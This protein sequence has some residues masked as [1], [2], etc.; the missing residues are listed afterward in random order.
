MKDF[1]NEQ[2]ESDVQSTEVSSEPTVAAVEQTEASSEAAGAAEQTKPESNVPYSRFQEV[3]QQKNQHA[4]QLK[5]MQGQY[6][7]MQAR[8]DAFER[9]QQARPQTEAQKDALIERLKGIDPE[10]GE[11]IEQ[12][13]S[14]LSKID[15]LDQWRAQQEQQTQYQRAMSA[16][17]RL[18]AEHKVPKELQD[19]Y[20]NQLKSDPHVNLDNLN[21]AYKNLHQRM[22]GY[23]DSVKRT[24]R[25]SYVA[26]KKADA[27]APT[28]QPKGK[29]PSPAQ[30]QAK[31]SE[32][33]QRET[34]DEVL[35][36]IR[37]GRE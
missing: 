24:E 30:K 35:S 21:E 26:A 13:Y 14:K 36:L 11:R 28:S 33:S 34:V 5:A 22:S 18:H 16:V 25:E 19:I 37:A 8:I 17:E 27:K 10:F 20:V 1:E 6:Q 29:A 7:Q 12:M 23:F 32:E 4:E 9:A 2:S 15:Q 31:G 3:I